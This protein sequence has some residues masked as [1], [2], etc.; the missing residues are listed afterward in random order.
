MAEQINQIARIVIQHGPEGG[1]LDP[2]LG[3]GGVGVIGP[4]AGFLFGLVEDL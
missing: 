1:G 3:A 4:A 2:M